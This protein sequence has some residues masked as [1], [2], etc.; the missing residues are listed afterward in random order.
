MLVGVPA[1]VGGARAAQRLEIG[2]RFQ[3]SQR[4]S[5][6]TGDGRMS[7]RVR[8]CLRR[9]QLKHINKYIK[10]KVANTNG[11]QCGIFANRFYMSVDVYA[12]VEDTR[13]AQCLESGRSF[14]ASKRARKMTGTPCLEGCELACA[15]TNCN[16]PTNT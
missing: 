12:R 1:R 11:D 10:K 3:A 13:A 4:A 2:R 8:V 14:Q 9:D 16:T 7:R 5:K 6:M 15:V